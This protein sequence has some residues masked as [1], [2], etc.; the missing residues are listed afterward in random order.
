MKLK[1]TVL[2]VGIAASAI[3]GSAGMASADDVQARGSIEV[4]PQ[5]LTC[6]NYYDAEDVQL[7]RGC[8][9]NVGDHVFAD[10]TNADGLW[11]R[12]EWE[13]NAGKTGECKDDGGAEGDGVDCNYDL[14]EADQ[15]RFHVEIWDGDAQQDETEWTGWLPISQ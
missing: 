10:D 6:I 4:T 3:F 8:F 13:T 7:G 1:S 15:L 11:V 12:T 2:A 5:G 9:N 14:P